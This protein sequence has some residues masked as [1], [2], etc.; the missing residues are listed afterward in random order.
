MFNKQQ[1]E[2]LKSVNTFP[3]I[4]TL[5]DTKAWSPSY[6]REKHCVENQPAKI[7]LFR[8]IAA[9]YSYHGALNHEINYTLC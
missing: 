3:Q 5:F 4:T 6:L 2:L 7:L 8:E 9:K 1:T